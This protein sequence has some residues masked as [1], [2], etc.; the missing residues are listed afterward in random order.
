MN[1]AGELLF[2]TLA[3]SVVAALMWL[4][5]GRRKLKEIDIYDLIIATAA[6]VIV[7]LGIADPS[8][9]TSRTIMATILLGLLYSVFRGIIKKMAIILAAKPNPITVVENGQILS[10]NLR[11]AR[12]SIPDLLALLRGK[13]IFDITRVELAV[14]ERHGAINVL[15]KPE[16]MPLTPEHLNIVSVPNKIFVPII[17]DGKL[18]EA[19][20]AKMGF[21]AQQIDDF[22]QQYN[23]QLQEVFIAFM[24]NKSRAIHIIKKEDDK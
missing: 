4:V 17:V 22:Y 23:Q 14:V 13:G 15:L 21:S 10:K 20:L 16:H 7:G 11:Q 19:E 5:M 6:G 12:V 9:E 2:D 1:N 24:D 3:G 18:Q 8:G